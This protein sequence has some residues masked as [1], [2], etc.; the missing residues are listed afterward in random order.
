MTHAVNLGLVK[1]DD[2]MELIGEK[3]KNLELVITGRDSPIELIEVADYVTEF[4]EQKHPYR[5]GVRARRGI[6]Y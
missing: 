3:P 1:I 5:K 4:V 6:E 2:V